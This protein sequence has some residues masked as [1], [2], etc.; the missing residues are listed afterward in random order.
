MSIN[1]VLNSC[2][3][4]PFL[5]VISEI[6]NYKLFK[7]VFIDELNFKKKA[8]FKQVGE[9]NQAVVAQ[10]EINKETISKQI[11]EGEKKENDDD[12]DVDSNL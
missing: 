3:Y 4:V 1:Y 12:T 8:K 2:Y 9:S 7:R 11:E 6:G 5:S 10:Q